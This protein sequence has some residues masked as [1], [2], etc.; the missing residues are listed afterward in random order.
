MNDINKFFSNSSP[1]N[2]RY[3]SEHSNQFILFFNHIYNLLLLY[4]SQQLVVVNEV[5]KLVLSSQL[6]R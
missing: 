4:F 1:K 2:R 3:F 5:F 6:Q